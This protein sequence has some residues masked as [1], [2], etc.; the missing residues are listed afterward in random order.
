MAKRVRER[1]PDGSD[2][3]V[4]RELY[5]FCLYRTFLAVLLAGMAFSPL[6]METVAVRMP[7]LVQVGATIYLLVAIVL[8]VI[9]E[10]VGL[11]SLT[12]AGAVFDLAAA[13]LAI[14]CLPEL[15]FTISALMIL[16][17]AGTAVLLPTRLGLMFAVLAAA[18]LILETLFTN[19]TAPEIDRSLLQALLVGA[20]YLLAARGSSWLALQQRH[21]QAL[22]ERRGVD[23]A[24][25]SQINELII[26][27]MRTGVLVVDDCN[28]IRQMNESAWLMLGSP[29]RDTH[30]S[31]R[32]VSAALAKRLKHWRDT[33]KNANESIVIGED[34]PEIIPSFARL[35]AEDDRIALVFLD[36]TSLLNR[37]AEELTLTSLG[38]LSASIAHEIRNPL[39][40][41]SYSAQL[42]D[43]SEELPESDKRL[44][45][46]I[47]N[48]CSRVN[49]IVENVL[50]LSRRE[51]SKPEEVDLAVWSEEFIADYRESHDIGE[52]QIKSIVR[53]R[54][55]LCLVDP[56]HLNQVMWTL[57][58]NA[59]RY[60][61]LPDQPAHV[62][63]VVHAVG[64]PPVPVVDV[65]DR[66][67]GIPKKVA[68]NIFEPFYTTSEYGNGLGLYLARQMCES[69]NASLHLI[70]IAAGGSCFRIALQ[71]SRRNREQ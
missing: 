13:L 30:Q 45:D 46:I 15:S 49:G 58:Q 8:L 26:Q 44:V 67:P 43:E 34:M 68:D 21:A 41:I 64:T 19:L 16:T 37:R 36:D 62:A 31:L 5:F 12:L 11:L 63:V 60:G 38:R 29:Q 28:L 47:R 2:P 42:L 71:A 14:H 48:H 22:A 70:P 40:A 27:R 66:G 57:L 65:M 7:L 55:V 25:L 10:R 52:S 24:N 9:R 54:P 51:R 23:V 18:G 33:R 61:R 56:Q 1:L 53:Q 39:A 35:S 50:Q 17:V 4:Q 20:T 59:L 3:L 32:F 69:S 6:A